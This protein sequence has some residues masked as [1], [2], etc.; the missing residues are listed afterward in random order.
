MTGGHQRMAFAFAIAAS[1]LARPVCRDE[2]TECANWARLGECDAN[3]NYMHES[4]APAC[5]TCGRRSTLGFTVDLWAEEMNGHDRDT[6]ANNARINRDQPPTVPAFTDV[7]V[8]TQVNDACRA[9]LE[10]WIGPKW[11]GLVPTSVYGIRRYT[12]GSTLQAHVDVVATH[13]VSA[14]LNVDQDVDE[15]WPL[16]IRDHGGDVH[17]V[18]MKPGEMVLY[19]SSKSIHGRLVPLNGASYDNIFVHFRPR[20]GWDRFTGVPNGAVLSDHIEL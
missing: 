14:I 13:A 12:N 16:Q 8:R 4:C 1:A 20:L 10:A 6:F 18:V 2:H 9:I 7:G 19:E 3:P 11:G 5:G 15:D 17:A